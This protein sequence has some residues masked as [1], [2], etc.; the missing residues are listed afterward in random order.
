MFF[1]KESESPAC[2]NLAEEAVACFESGLNCTQAVLSVY[3]SEY[4]LDR[5]AVLKISAPFGSGMGMGETCGAVTGAL[6]VIGL[7]EA[8][9][10]RIRL[11]KEKAAEAGKQF[12]QRFRAREGAVSCRELLG[13]DPSTSEGYARARKENSFKERCPGFVRAAAEILEELARNK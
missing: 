2:L 5:E 11:T 4:G 12:I 1:R 7:R 3:G 13:C 8:K 6:M 10:S 9:M